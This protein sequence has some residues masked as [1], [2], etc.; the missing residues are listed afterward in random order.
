MTMALTASVPPPGRPPE[1][2]SFTGP[3]TPALAGLARWFLR[4]LLLATGHR[5]SQLVSVAQLCVSEVVTNAH[6]H[7]RAP[8]VTVSVTVT[9]RQVTV[10]V[11]DDSTALPV[12]RALSSKAERGRGLRI[13]D[14][15][16]ADW[17][18]D[19]YGGRQPQSKSVWFRLDDDG[20]HDAP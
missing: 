20:R 8:L 9:D 16:A 6:R 17:G 19:L 10:H 12:A 5:N 7:T 13:L 3:N 11:H 4:D 14:A 18:T 1:N 15:F 2:Y